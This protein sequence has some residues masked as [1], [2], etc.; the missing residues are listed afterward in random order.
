M[1]IRAVLRVVATALALVLV[2]GCAA[3][4]LVA[5]RTTGSGLV[6]AHPT[7]TD[8]RS[9]PSCPATDRQPLVSTTPGAP[10][11]LV[12]DGPHAVLLCRY[13]GL[14][15][16]PSESTHLKAQRLDTQPRTVAGLASLFNA[17]TPMHSGSYSCP[18]DFG[19][20]IIAI[21][22]YPTMSDDP[23]TLDPGGCALV[24]NGHLTRTASFTP[25]PKLIRQLEG[26][27]S[28]R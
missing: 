28:K 4:A 8:R 10:E 25:G 17:L 18:A 27:T 7:T 3:A 6:G 24:T 16:T 20:K 23:V 2:S 1:S 5:N 22:R 21:F 9:H 13:R 12:P 15:P 14:N 26:L 19:V 11:T